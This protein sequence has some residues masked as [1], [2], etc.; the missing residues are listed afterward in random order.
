MIPS[1]SKPSDNESSAPRVRALERD[2]A[3]KLLRKCCPSDEGKGE[4]E[5]G[6]GGWGVGK[7]PRLDC[8]FRNFISCTI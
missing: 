2:G 4:E 5:K 8:A 7:L 3:G 6:A 1:G